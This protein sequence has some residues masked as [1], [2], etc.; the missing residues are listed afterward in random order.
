MVVEIIHN[1]FVRKQI[2]TT[3]HKTPPLY[4]V[5]IKHSQQIRRL[6]VF[7]CDL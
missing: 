4:F 1:S 7:H 5:V 3:H 6:C 2:L